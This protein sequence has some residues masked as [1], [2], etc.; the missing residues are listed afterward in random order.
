MGASKT[1]AA[2]SKRSSMTQSWLW[3]SSRRCPTS[4]AVGS[5]NAHAPHSGSW[6]PSPA[7]QP[8]ERGAI[9]SAASWRLSA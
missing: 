7:H 3:K 9:S 1:R 8:V 4:S 6:R 2:G 5:G